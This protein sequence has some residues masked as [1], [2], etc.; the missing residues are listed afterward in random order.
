V[1]WGG[2]E[3]TRLT[4]P[5]LYFLLAVS[6]FP[7]TKLPLPA[8]KSSPMMETTFTAVL[9][10]PWPPSLP[11]PWRMTG[12]SDGKEARGPIRRRGVPGEEKAQPQE[13][14]EK[15]RTPVKT[16]ANRPHATHTSQPPPPDS[17]ASEV[18]AHLA[19][20]HISIDQRCAKIRELRA[21]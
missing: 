6:Y 19:Y 4:R 1:R 13:E 10:C 5:S 12:G 2:I 18:V 17:T 8:C 21:L 7:S 3:H 11:P 9:S 20:H 15:D 14:H 16:V